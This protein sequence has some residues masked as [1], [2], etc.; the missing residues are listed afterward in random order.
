M[1][2][3]MALSDSMSRDITMASGGS[4][5]S[6]IRLFLST[7]VSPVLPAFGAQTLPLLFLAQLSTTF[8]LINLLP[9]GNRQVPLQCLM[10]TRAMC[11]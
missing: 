9:R 11:W 2:P 5:S 3:D 4:A 7:L 10:S 6:Y 1:D 8:L